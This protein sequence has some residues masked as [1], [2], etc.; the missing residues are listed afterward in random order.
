[1]SPNKKTIILVVDDQENNR[2]LLKGLLE[3]DGYTVEEAQDGFEG[4]AKSAMEVDL[5][6]LDVMMPNIDGFEVARRI[7]A[8]PITVDI[9]ILMV[10]A[11]DGKQ[12]RI[13]AVEAGANDFIGKPVDRL[14]M[15]VRVRSLLKIKQTQDSLRASNE[16]LEQKVARQT[17][18]LRTALSEMAASQRV[19]HEAHLDTINRLA[20]AAEYKDEDTAEHI[21][22]MA[23]YATMIGQLVGMTTAET[24]A[25]YY[26]SFMHDVGKIGTPDEILL[27]PGK[28]TAGERLK[29]QEHT[30]IGA[31]ILG[32]S[33]SSLLQTG[34]I[35][36]LTHHE[37]WD[38]TGYPNGLVGEGIPLWGRICAIADVYDALTSKR[39]YKEPFPQKKAIEILRQGRGS[40]FD[41]QLLDLFLENSDL[42]VNTETRR[43]YASNVV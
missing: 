40:H 29:M 5:I 3:L 2:E 42:I 21:Y 9:P 11:L 33:P 31:R 35:V 4:L 43:S 6:L 1:M 38:G 10:T 39:P 15:Q 24:D 13:Q 34:E 37:K 22:R 8:N 14:E 12:E 36:A 41:P 16:E 32:K 19:A 25:L 17:Q 26:A 27:K 18:D 20:I 30:L 28:L 7:R 23:H